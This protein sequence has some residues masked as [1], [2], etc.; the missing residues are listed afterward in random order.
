MTWNFP[1]AFT[2]D[3]GTKKIDSLQ[4]NGEVRKD[5]LNS[6]R[7]AQK[8]LQVLLEISKLPE[9]E[10]PDRTTEERRRGRDAAEYP[11]FCDEFWQALAAAASFGEPARAAPR[12]A[13]ASSAS[14][15]TS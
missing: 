3:K 9:V 4:N 7:D 13:A 5:F 1:R 2:G 6:L 15:T 10:E 11:T 14:G 12:A 8:G